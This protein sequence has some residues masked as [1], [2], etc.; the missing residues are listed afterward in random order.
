MERADAQYEAAA[1]RCKTL[2]GNEREVCA[3]EAK[4]AAE[5]AKADADA[6]YR[7]TDTQRDARIH[8]A[9]ADYLVARA[10]CDA[11]SGDKKDACIKEAKRAEADAVAAAKDSCI[12]DAKAKYGK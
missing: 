7:N 10:K 9:Q 3:A 6:A 2:S 11:M 4:A 5:K 8:D 1:A 12:N